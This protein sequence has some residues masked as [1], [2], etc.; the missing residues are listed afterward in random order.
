[1]NYIG[2][3]EYWNE[4]FILKKEENQLIIKQNFFIYEGI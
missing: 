1:M 2:N 4:K 3:K